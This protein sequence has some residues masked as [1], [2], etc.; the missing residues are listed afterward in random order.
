VGEGN[1]TELPEDSTAKC[2]TLEFPNN[3]SA[4]HF[5]KLT[6]VEGDKTISGNF[7]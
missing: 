5:I 4:V 1:H 7:Y 2:F 6:L 3:L